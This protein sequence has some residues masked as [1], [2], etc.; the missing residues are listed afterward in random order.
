MPEVGQKFGRWHDVGYWQLTL[1][2]GDG[3]PP[4]MRLVADVQEA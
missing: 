4:T 1:R 3:P 2:E